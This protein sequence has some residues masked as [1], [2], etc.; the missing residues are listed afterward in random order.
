MP[1][2]EM[3]MILTISVPHHTKEL[4]EP[5]FLYPQL[6]L[7]FSRGEQTPLSTSCSKFLFILSVTRTSDLSAR[8]SSSSSCSLLRMA[9]SWL[10]AAAAVVVP[11][12]GGGCR[13][14]VDTLESVSLSSV[15]LATIR[16]SSSF[17]LSS[18][19]SWCTC[20]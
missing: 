3:F 14:G 16:S 11:A 12:C 1:G 17:L 7:H 5:N 19:W 13:C 4:S 10:S 9:S 8:F 15:A 6:H 2:A 20:R 18:C